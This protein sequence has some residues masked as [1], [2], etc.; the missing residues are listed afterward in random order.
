MR[1]RKRI[2]ATLFTVKLHMESS[3]KPL[4]LQELAPALQKNYRQGFAL[5]VILE[6]GSFNGIE[7]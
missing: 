3:G 1:R 4:D 7:M 2:T 6:V 5:S